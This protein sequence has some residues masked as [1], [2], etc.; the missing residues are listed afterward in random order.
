MTNRES[1]KLMLWGCGRIAQYFHLNILSQME[2]VKLVAIADADPNNLQKAKQVTP[3]AATF[4]DYTDSLDIAADGVVI[5]LPP[6]LHA[7]SAIS[8][9]EAG[10]ACYIEKPMAI[11][12]QQATDVRQAWQ[13]SGKIG[14]MG[15][16][17]RYHPRYQEL[18]SRLAEIGDIRSSQS[19]FTSMGEGLPDWKKRRSTGGGVLLDLASHHI[20][21]AC[22]L[23][24]AEVETANA[25]ITTHRAEF[26]NAIVNLK[27]D[28]DILV[29][30]LVSLKST[31]EHR[32]DV[33]GEKGRL[34]VDLFNPL[35][36]TKKEATW[37]GARTKKILNRLRALSPQ[38]LLI[39]PAYAPSYELALTAYV[40]GLQTNQLDKVAATIEDGYRN[41]E[42]IFNLENT[43]TL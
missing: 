26:D 37:Q 22:F 9:F 17:Y 30:S 23:F 11:N 18:K 3:D 20:D 38:E 13:A 28:N 32:W 31:A 1:V 4:A 14:M 34:S 39:T 42:I 8:A 24:Q 6:A 7:P 40:N 16:N 36:V 12:M 2:S 15:F 27:L 43:K 29:Q 33:Y 25:L 19:V 35:R 41:A 10:L 5:C 21:L